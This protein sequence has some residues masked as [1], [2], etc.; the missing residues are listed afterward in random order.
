MSST[1]G[2]RG[3]SFWPQWHENKPFALVLLLIG[4][5]T[6]ILLM[7]KI[8]QIQTETQEIGEPYPVEHT[9]TVEG[10]G[11]VSGTP[12]VATVTIG[13][14]TKDQDS[15]SA[16]EQNSTTVNALLEKIKALGIESADIQ[17]SN[18]S[19]YENYVW[20]PDTETSESDGWIVSQTLTVKVRD[21]GRVSALLSVAGQNG[22]TSV[23][24]PNFEI[25]DASKL[26]M[27]A[28]AEAIADARAKAEALAAAL[29]VELGEV[30]SYSEGGGDYPYYYDSYYSGLERS[31]GGATPEVEEGSSQID[32]TVS[33][34]YRIDD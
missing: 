30:V 10:E 29:G 28:R 8:D 12:D 20:N 26:K 3:P 22:A 17:T 27:E 34:T 7:A 4:S 6:V 32:V 9:I 13:V 21:T 16:Q 24:G 15:A 31:V 11:S 33:I 19:V 25:D 5:F 2:S 14:D 1:G 23:Y 18:Y